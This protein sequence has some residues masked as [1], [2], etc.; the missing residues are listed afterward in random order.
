M[1]L[2]LFKRPPKGLCRCTVGSGGQIFDLEL[3]E[4]PVYIGKCRILNLDIVNN[5]YRDIRFRKHIIKTENMQNI[6]SQ[7]QVVYFYIDIKY[8]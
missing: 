5:L 4:F 7:Y 1:Y 6:V 2:Y 8:L 3:G